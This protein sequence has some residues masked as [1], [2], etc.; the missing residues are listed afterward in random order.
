MKKLFAGLVASIM[1]AGLV[2]GL[3]VSSASAEPYPGSVPTFCK[4]GGPDVVQKGDRARFWVKVDSDAN[5][6]PRGHVTLRVNRLNGGYS[7]MD[8]KAYD[9]GRVYFT[10]D[11]LKQIGKYQARAR[12][13]GKAGSKWADCNNVQTFKVVR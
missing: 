3:T 9:G 12:F 8:V 10:T 6:T 5:G 1:M 11:P 2:S 13:D 4:I 7:F